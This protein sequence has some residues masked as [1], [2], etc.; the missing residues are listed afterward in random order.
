M[1]TVRMPIAMDAATVW[2]LKI[3]V[4]MVKIGSRVLVLFRIISRFFFV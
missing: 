4:M 1:P 2:V 3:R